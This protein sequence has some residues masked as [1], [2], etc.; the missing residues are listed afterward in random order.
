MKRLLLSA[1]LL[2]VWST[3]AYAW[4]SWQASGT[5]TGGE[6]ADNTTVTITLPQNVGQ[7][8]YMYV[9]TITTGTVAISGSID[10]TTFGTLY[11]ESGSAWA[12][13]SG[14]GGLFI[15]LPKINAYYQIKITTGAEQVADRVFILFGK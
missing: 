4:S 9:P 13:G 12:L 1:L 6:V 3:S 11:L 15:E 14:S 2:L 8:S 5:L 7:D 10:G